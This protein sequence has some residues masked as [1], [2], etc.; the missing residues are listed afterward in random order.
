MLFGDGVAEGEHVVAWEFDNP[1]ALGTDEVV[2][3]L[4]A[5]TFS[6]VSLFHVETDFLENAAIHQQRKRAVNGGFSD[7]LT[8]L[9]QREQQLFRFKVAFDVQDRLQNLLARHGVSDAA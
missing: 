2:V 1:A 7:T 3:G 9:A 8:F 4:F 6:V 5:E